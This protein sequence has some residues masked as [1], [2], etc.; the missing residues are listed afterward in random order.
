MNH[1]ITTLTLPSEDTPMVSIDHA[2]AV[3]ERE[4]RNG[5]QAYAKISGR[6]WTYYVKT[7]RVNLGRPADPVRQSSESGIQTSP[8][9]TDV[10]DS[11][12]H[13]DLG[14][15]K[16]VSRQHATIEYDGNGQYN[17]QMTVHGRNGVRVDDMFIKR[18]ETK[19]L[20]SGMVLEI[21]GT[22]MM[23]VTPDDHPVVHPTFI[24]QARDEDRGIIRRSNHS[25]QVF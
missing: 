8:P 15:S 6:D 19:G 1:V 5:V 22:Q 3:H 18:G 16:L 12:V 21:G 11:K 4:H 14:P 13:I 17:W 2:N 20:T 25:R 24:Q 10:E 23:F 7:L 9:P